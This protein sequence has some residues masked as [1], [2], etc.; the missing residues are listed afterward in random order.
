MSLLLPRL[1]RRRKAATI[2]LVVTV[3]TRRECCCC[4]K[5]IDLLKDRRKRHGFTLELV[6]IDT[7][8]DLVARHGQWVPVVMFGDKVRFRGVVNPVLLDRLLAAE[9][10]EARR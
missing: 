2:P 1:L 10:R 7:D 4:H 5:A 6:D 9:G 3:F 8:P